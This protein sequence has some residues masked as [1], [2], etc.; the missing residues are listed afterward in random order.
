MAS[1]DRHRRSPD[2]SNYSSLPSAF[3][4]E[5]P[6][7]ESSRGKLTR[8]PAVCTAYTLFHVT[9]SD[10]RV[11]EVQRKTDIRVILL[12][13]AEQAASIARKRLPPL[14]YDD[15]ASRAGSLQRSK[16]ALSR[17]QMRRAPTALLAIVA[18]PRT[19]WSPSTLLMTLV[20]HIRFKRGRARSRMR[21]VSRL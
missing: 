18:F 16:R 4:S 3:A 12:H 6:R 17:R 10:A 8:A 11:F 5:M 15:R 13:N 20:L 21:F 1:I 19:P 9:E 7:D 14:S 2:H